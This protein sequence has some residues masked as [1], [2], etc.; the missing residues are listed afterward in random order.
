ME[1]VNYRGQGLAKAIASN[2]FR[3]Y[4]PKFSPNDGLAHADVG[5]ENLQSQGVCNSLGGKAGWIV[6]WYVPT[7]TMFLWNPIKF[8]HVKM[9]G[10]VADKSFAL[11]F[12]PVIS[13]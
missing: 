7:K 2:L 13:R 9:Q 4:V 1:Q 12:Y 10:L 8:N 11:D 6:H 3:N 5:M